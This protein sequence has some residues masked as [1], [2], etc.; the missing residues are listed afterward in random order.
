M[1]IKNGWR[2][3]AN[4]E[5]NL[6]AFKSSFFDPPFAPSKLLRWIQNVYEER[7]ALE[8]L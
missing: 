8:M 1:K 6:D 2:K 5:A 3:K 7:E 4:P